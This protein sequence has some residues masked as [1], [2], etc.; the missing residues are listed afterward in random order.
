[1]MLLMQR[2]YAVSKK[3]EII[4]TSRLSPETLTA[5]KKLAEKTMMEPY[6]NTIADHLSSNIFVR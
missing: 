2:T 6:Y 4:N 1:M 3:H 5:L